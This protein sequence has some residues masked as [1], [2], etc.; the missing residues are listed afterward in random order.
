MSLCTQIQNALRSFVERTE[1]F[2][3]SV[4][5]SRHYQQEVAVTDDTGKMLQNKD[6][7]TVSVI[8]RHRGGY[9]CRLII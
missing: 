5:D 2:P 9:K 6:F 1:D 4:S 8:Q 3:E 7:T